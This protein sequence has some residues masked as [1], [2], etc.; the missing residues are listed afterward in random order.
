M[1]SPGV[2][3]SAASPPAVDRGDVR[4]PRHVLYVCQASG[5]MVSVF[6]AAKRQM[7]ASVDQLRADGPDPQTFNVCFFQDER[8]LTLSARGPLP[9]TEANKRLAR[10]FIAQAVPAGSTHT[11]WAIRQI[12][13]ERADV[14]DLITDGLSQL[15]PAERSAVEHAFARA[16][17]A[18]GHGRIDCTYLQTSVDPALAT[19]VANIARWSGGT[20]R[21]LSR[22]DP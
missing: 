1:M 12:A 8:V 18:N 9:A 6:A 21:T 10:A 3:P 13:A 11:G 16:A 15:P 22:R 20:V 7:I 2:M 17:T 4:P 14:V 5:S 19:S